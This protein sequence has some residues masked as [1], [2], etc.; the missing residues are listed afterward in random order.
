[1][2]EN[3]L[4]KIIETHKKGESVGIYSVCS[5]NR[6]V[7][8]ASMLQAKKDESILL[9]ESTSNQVDQFGGYT[10]MTPDKFVNFVFE[11]ASSLQYPNDMLILGGDH[12]GPNVWQS[13]KAEDAMEKAKELIRSYVIAGFCKI[14]LDTSMRCA[15]D[16]GDNKTPLNIQTIAD[17]TAELCHVSETACRNRQKDMPL[18]LYVIGTEVP[19]P[20]GAQE[21][22]SGIHI[23][24]IDDVEQTI[25]VIKNA[26]IMHDL[27]SAWERVIAVVVQPGVEFSDSVI[28]YYDQ[29][30]ARDLS[31]FI[32][33]K[34]NI[35]YE[36]HS[37]DYQKKEN[38]KQMV[39]DHFAIL[40]VGPALTF[41]FR[42]AVFGLAMIENEYLSNKSNITLSNIKDTIDKIMVDKPK[43]W[44]KHYHGNDLS[45]IFSRKYSYSDRIRYYWPDP[46]VDNSL[47]VLIK[48]LIKYP[49]PLPILS[50]YM[51]LQ[52]NAILENKIR[53]HPIDIIHNK[54]MEV[55][56]IYSYATGSLK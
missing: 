35:I 28:I 21:E 26:F 1:M 10:G 18:P 15:D 6:I 32:E 40:K 55:T 36:A 20:G 31:Q 22:L 43:Y 13:Q 44:E 3:P 33:N 9:I 39:E 17:R 19:I 37:T 51:P 23:T 46:V 52:Y 34:E 29:E 45:L 12:L 50:Q 11:I 25:D 5:A 49:A 14:H 2:I 27:E 4:K 41:A 24:L 54:I 42:E 8:E 56:N 16:S 38:L 30:K 53:N 47:S 48:N 7:I